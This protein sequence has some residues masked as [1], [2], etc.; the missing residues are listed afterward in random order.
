[1]SDSAIDIRPDKPLRGRGASA[2]PSGRHEPLQRVPV[3]D[4][5][6]GDG[7]DD[8]PPLRTHVT[9]E[10]CR[11][12]I[13]YNQ[14]PD[15]P[16]DRSINPY[17]GCEHGC[18]YCFARPSHANMGLSPGLDFESR[19]F[20]KPNV[21]TVLEG[22]LRKKGYACRPIALGT[23]TDPYQ[24]IERSRRLTRSILEVL[25]RYRH[26][27]T[28]VTKS[29]LV[30]RD[31]DILGP[32]AEASLASV[33]VSVTTL[34]RR[35]SNT[36]EPRAPIPQKRLAA[37]RG[38]AA[39]GVP[40][41]VFAAPMIPVINDAELERIVAAGAAAGATQA[42]YMLLKLPH[43]L[44]DLFSDWLDAHAPGKAAHV[45]SLVR[46]L[47]GGRL[48]DSSFHARMTGTGTFA[49]LLAGRFRLACRK[50]GIDGIG[51]RTEPGAMGLDCTRFRPPPQAGDQMD[52]FA[53]DS[54]LA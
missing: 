49:E 20:A 43:E 44:G 53:A 8:A 19:L 10:A 32:M 4:G 42:A 18:S 35:L 40:T 9:D 2:N 3:D 38:L 11:T 26:P 5:W 28:I 54:E 1:M 51:G 30:L 7:E 12:A 31:L 27:V 16:F 39:G 6:G 34:D 50:G 25:A 29:D 21:A 17:R 13:T 45:L 52:M 33:A 37:I 24:P 36:L 48:N 14:S 15:L 41:A 23:N 22:E 46:Q 47:R